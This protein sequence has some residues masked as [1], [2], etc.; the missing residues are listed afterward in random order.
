[1]YQDAQCRSMYETGSIESRTGDFA[2]CNTGTEG[3]F[4]HNLN[5]FY[6]HQWYPYQYHTTIVEDKTKKAFNIAKSLMDKKLVECKTVKQFIDL[7]D[8]IINI[9]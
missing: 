8:V 3:S 9:L 1:M 5:D 6:Y 4:S 7:I 2:V